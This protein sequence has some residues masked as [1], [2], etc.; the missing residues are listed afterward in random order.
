MLLQNNMRQPFA[1]LFARV[2]PLDNVGSALAPLYVV[3]TRK[4]WTGKAI[5]IS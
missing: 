2:F 3:Y 5:T 1:C 4:R